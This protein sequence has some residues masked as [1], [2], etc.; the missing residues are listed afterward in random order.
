MQR[1]AL[2]HGEPG[3][4]PLLDLADALRG[5]VQEP[6]PIGVSSTGS[7]RPPEGRSA[8]ATG[9]RDWSPRRSSLIVCL[10]TKAPRAGSELDVAGV[11]ARS[12]RQTYRGVVGPNGRSASSIR[13]RRTARVCFR[14]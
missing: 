2:A 13:E 6:P 1:A 12:S 9:P 14:R 4:H 10:V 7:A 8:R 3:D 11:R 5:Q